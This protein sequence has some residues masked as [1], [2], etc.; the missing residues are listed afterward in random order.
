LPEDLKHIQV[1]ARKIDDEIDC[2]NTIVSSLIGKL[3]YLG[4]WDSAEGHLIPRSLEA[5]V[6]TGY[7][8]CKEYSLCAAAVLNGLGYQ[9]KVALVKRDEVYLEENNLPHLAQFNH[10]ILKV[11][12]PSRRIYWIDPT[13]R[14]SMA[15]GIYPDIADR[16]ALVL[17]PEDPTYEHIPPIDYRHARVNR[18]DT[19]TINDEGYVETSGFFSFHGET[20]Q[21]LIEALKMHQKSVVREGLIRSLCYGGNPIN[22]TLDLPESI[23]PKVQDLKATYTYEDPN[24][25]L[26]T[27][28]GYAF[29][30]RTEWYEPYMATSQKHEGA[31]FV[32]HPETKVRKIIFKNAYAEDLNSL[33]FSIQTPWLNAKRELLLSDNGTTIIETIEK[34]KSVIPAKD[35]KSHR[36]EEL[37][38]TL[39]K[40][41]RV[42]VVFSKLN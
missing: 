10:A 42:A 13:N 34:L 19:T 1:I 39:C 14:T 3:T 4:S 7:A 23:S 8:D 29:S 22:F 32:G 15:D 38:K 17:D 24:P 26:L 31:I 9:A 27:N 11:V 6:N 2:I 20:A 12:S 21:K 5:I 41:S 28:C 33:A 18:V 37:R 36:F 35:L 30:P 25:L 40:C 16:P